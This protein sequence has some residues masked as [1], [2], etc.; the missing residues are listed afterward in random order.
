MAL[1]GRL[2][3]YGTLRFSPIIRAV[4]GRIPGHR[5]ATAPGYACYAVKGRPYPAL[6]PEAGAAAAGVLYEGLTREEIV[7]LDDYE[8]PEYRRRLIGIEEAGGQRATAW[9][10]I[11]KAQHR[12]RLTSNE[13][14]IKEFE[15]RDLP[16]YLSDLF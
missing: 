12:S 7:R 16:A 5:P 11:W 15:R 2:F 4:I 6:V 13:W 1:S 10:Y 9:G 8:G 14:D 3:C